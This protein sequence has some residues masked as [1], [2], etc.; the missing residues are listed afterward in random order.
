MTA[1]PRRPRRHVRLGL[2]IWLAAAACALSAR[3]APADPPPPFSSSADASGQD[4]LVML[5]M[6]PKHLRPGGD[7]GGDY[8]VGLDNAARRRI[9]SRLAHEHDLAL[10]DNWPM[11]LIGVDCFVMGVP[12]GQS[13][14]AVAT[15]LSH[16]P[17]VAWAEPLQ[18]YRAQGA[19]KIPDDPLF[20]VQPAAIEWRLAELHELATGRK[21]TVAVVDSMVERT[22]PDL[23]GQVPVSEDFVTGHGGTPERHGTGV[24]GIIAAKANNGVGIVGIAP[25]ASLMA[26]RACWQTPGGDAGGAATVCDSLSLAKALQ[27]AVAHDAQVINLSLAG[28]PDLLL[29]RLLDVAIARG[30]TVVG[31]VDQDLPGGGFPAS[32]PGVVAVADETADPPADGVYT[33]PGRDVPT[34]QPG[35][36]WYFVNGSSYSAAHVSG[37]FALLRERRPKARGAGAL[38]AARADG[39]AIDACATLLR[40]LGPRDCGC[41]HPRAD[42]AIARR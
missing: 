29:G 19:L 23:I 26:L 20:P 9:A 22:H 10:A 28:P 15:L 21:V 5:R 24:A 35:G 30:V 41:A 27:F 37:L 42:A 4:V 12:A 13:P 34:T 25:D 17:S 31:S 1:V 6:P 40:A 2:A 18:L 36:R 8:G 32:H 3:A 39:G 7:Y 38:V 16:D 11:P 14:D 33:A